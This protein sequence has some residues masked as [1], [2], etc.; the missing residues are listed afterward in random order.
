[1]SYTVAQ[2]G[3]EIIGRIGWI[4][5]T[6]LVGGS[7]AILVVGLGA[8]ALYRAYIWWVAQDIDKRKEAAMTTHGM[9]T[10]DSD[11]AGTLRRIDNVPPEAIGAPEQ[12][13]QRPE[14]P[15]VTT[16]SSC[17]YCSAEAP[18]TAKF[19]PGCGC[20]VGE[21]PEEAPMRYCTQCSEANDPGATECGV[22]GWALQDS[23]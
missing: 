15:K 9:H 19:C 20:P 3:G 14:P 16:T 1:M 18:T 2:T 5:T 6:I 23:Q 22:C 12:T 11:A 21:L 17:P 4:L 10:I 13:A 8:Y 7:G